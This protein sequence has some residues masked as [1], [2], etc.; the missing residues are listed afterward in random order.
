MH[1]RGQA[2]SHSLLQ[3][4]VHTLIGDWLNTVSANPHQDRRHDDTEEEW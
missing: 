3:P 4:R 2:A 1:E